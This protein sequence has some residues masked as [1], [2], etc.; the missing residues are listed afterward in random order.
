VPIS[1]A[2]YGLEPA[3]ATVYL[4]RK[5]TSR[6]ADKPEQPDVREIIKDNTWISITDTMRNV[7]NRVY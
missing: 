5:S 4:T 7:T 2:S 1:I 6:D 3:S